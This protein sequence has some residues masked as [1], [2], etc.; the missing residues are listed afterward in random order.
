[1]P[2]LDEDGDEWLIQ[3][4][5][6]SNALRNYLVNQRHLTRVVLPWYNLVTG[7]EPDETPE[8]PTTDDPDYLDK[9]RLVECVALLR[10][11]STPSKRSA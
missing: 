6:P 1:M 7:S 9:V 2:V 3:S 5:S 4:K 10:Q 8:L 11:R